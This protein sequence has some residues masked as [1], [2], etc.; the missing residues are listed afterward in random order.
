MLKLCNYLYVIAVLMYG[1]VLF[2][3][4][5]N[6]TKS[7]IEEIT[8]IDILYSKYQSIK[9][10]FIQKDN[11]GNTSSGWFVIQKPG[12]ARIE[13]QDVPIRFIANNNSLLFQD[14]QLKQK[15]FFPINASPFSYLLDKNFSFLS[16]KIKIVDYQVLEDYISITIKSTQNL[17]IGSLTLFLSKD[18]A[19]IIKWTIVDAKGVA[20]DV[21][22]VSP[23]FSEFAFTNQTIFNVQRIKSVKFNDLKFKSN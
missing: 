5:K 8:Q 2:A 9:S 4:N 20:S 17:D 3:E 7:M 21:F 10:Q 23:E 13:Y 19:E 14:L 18:K 1:N 12:L 6:L 11:L 15:S 16:D 22:L